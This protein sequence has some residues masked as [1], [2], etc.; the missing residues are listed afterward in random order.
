M[1]IFPRPA[2]FEYPPLLCYSVKSLGSGFQIQ[3]QELSFKLLLKTY[4][5]QVIEY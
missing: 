5:L 4:G 3:L 2:S 1:A